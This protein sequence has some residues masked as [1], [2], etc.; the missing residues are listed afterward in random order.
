MNLVEDESMSGAA[1]REVGQGINLNS[2]V[3][4][5]DGFQGETLEL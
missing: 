5:Q 4:R 1:G 3:L 2:F